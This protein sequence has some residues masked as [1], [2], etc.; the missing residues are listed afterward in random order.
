MAP[1]PKPR[2]DSIIERS[3]AAKA[4]KGFKF[5][6]RLMVTNPQHPNDPPHP[7]WPVT[8]TPAGYDDLV[9]DTVDDRVTVAG[10]RLAQILNKIWP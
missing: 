10:Y 2:A 3:I 4:H 1:S 7:D 9:R 5:G 6:K 8:K